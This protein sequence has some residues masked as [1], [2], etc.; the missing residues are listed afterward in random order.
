MVRFDESQHPRGGDPTNRG[1]FSPG[2]IGEPETELS[3][4]SSG[5]VPGISTHLMEILES[6]ADLQEKIPDAVLVGGSVSALYAGHRT[7]YDHDHILA[8]LRDRH[9]A[10]LDALEEEDEWVTN[11]VVPGKLILGQLGDIEAGVR[12]LIRKVP[13]EVSEVSLPSGKMLTVP[14]KEEALRIKAFLIVK[15]NQVR[16]YLDVAAM[17][18]RYGADFAADTLER[19]DQYYTDPL[20]EDYPVATQL[21]RQLGHPEPKDA[22]TIDRLARYKD[23]NPRWH[24][25]ENTEQILAEVSALMVQRMVGRQC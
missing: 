25:W 20:R 7:S 24:K 22:R 21:I 2:E 11:R 5:S 14:T 13:L 15:R 17:S 6:A 3:S 23:L 18:N 4:A 12:Q 1:R 19:I 16:D 9:E 10:I 8:D